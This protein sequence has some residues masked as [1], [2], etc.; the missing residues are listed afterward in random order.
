MLAELAA[1]LREEAVR[2]DERRLLVLA[3]AHSRSLEAA[4]NAL[5]AAGID[6]SGA[7]HVGE[8]ADLGCERVPLDRA[9]DLL[10]MTNAAVIFDAHAGLRP[11][12][13]GRVLG[14]VDGGGLFV[15]C[16]PPLASW[17]D[18][19]DP[20]DERFAV[21]PFAVEDVSGRFK[22]RFIE[23]LRAHPGIAIVDVDAEA[24]TTDGLTNPVRRSESASQS[25][26]ADAAFPPAAYAACRTQDQAAA[27]HALEK[28]RQPGQAV[29]LESD[30]GRGKSSVVGLA[31]AGLAMADWAVTITAPRYRSAREA[32]RRADAL[33]D[34]L[35]IKTSR[36]DAEAP[37]QLQL[38]D[39]ATVSFLPP[40]DIGNEDHEILIVDEAAG[41]GV[42]RL[43]ATLA[44]DR[45][46]YATTVH[47]YEGAGRG[48]SVRFRDALESSRHAVS[49]LELQ[50]PIRY[51]PGDPIEVWAFR[52]LLLDARPAVAP[53][54]AEAQPATT[55]YAALEPKTLQA[56]EPLLREAFGLLVLAHYRTE[57]D[58]LVRLLDAPN[59][60]VR[61]LLHDGHVASIAL[62]AREGGLSADLRQRMYEGG[63]VRG[64][65]LPDLLTSQLRDEAAGKAVGWRVLRL[66]THPAVRRRGLGS[67][68]LTELHDELGAD[69]D[70]F[71]TGYGATPELLS[72]WVEAGYGTIHLSTTRNDESGEHS[73]LMLRP[74][75]EE[76][77]A[78]AA[79][80]W[81]WF[82]RRIVDQLPDPLREVDPDIV[83][84][85]LR[86]V[87]VSRTPDLDD[88][89]WRLIA[90]MAYG[91]GLLDVDPGP[92]R[93][94]AAAHLIDLDDPHLLDADAERL[95]VRRVLQA[96]S[97]GTV[98]EDLDYPSRAACMRATG[99]AFRS[100]LSAYGP[101]W[102]EEQQTRYGH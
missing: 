7:I 102:V 5:R 17:P 28:L 75:S 54:V 19:Q 47:G 86:S 101:K 12:T 77:A 93:E 80:H 66:A 16:C 41:F 67:R 6:R 83:R 85:T 78:I 99:A 32:F 71:G 58:D 46:A 73:A 23:T 14:A 52:A 53:A 42:P 59:V 15:L 56:D 60:R 74:T 49:D 34:T 11:T 27:L 25:A 4:E 57:P 91:P 9:A 22:A 69:V 97:W 50:E 61:A 39:G 100:L 45:V 81:S 18:R 30:R 44:T 79:R 89:D 51:A 62:L 70:W 48:F 10:G 63:R 3:G 65:M 43:Q 76:G 20:A 24:I 94:L 33:L 72:F 35:G 31:G 37:R 26:P 55:R 98:A 36:D 13:L 96:Q 29:I 68:L 21:P 92:F 40:A 90:G 87:A 95:L 1:E 88:R 64:N 8:T 2:A 84:A 82:A 38:D